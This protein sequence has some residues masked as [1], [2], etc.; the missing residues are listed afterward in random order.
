ML[1][2]EL[3]D[4]LRALRNNDITVNGRKITGARYDPLIDTVVIVC[5]PDE[6]SIDDLALDEGERRFLAMHAT[7]ESKR[8][9][10][11]RYRHGNAI[12]SAELRARWQEIA[13]A[14]HE[15]P[16]GSKA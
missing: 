15:D 6:N 9:E 14:F 4:V 7:Y 11:V 5:E 13:D 8:Q 16:W 10:D 12:R 2:H 3:A 1:S